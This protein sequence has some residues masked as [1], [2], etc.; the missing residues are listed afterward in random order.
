MNRQWVNASLINCVS[1]LEVAVE[2]DT[3]EP[4]ANME[5]IVEPEHANTDDTNGVKVKVTVEKG[6]HVYYMIDFGDAS[7]T[8]DDVTVPVPKIGLS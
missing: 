7:N 6:S 4:I 3:V 2:V 5:L 1:E 8:N